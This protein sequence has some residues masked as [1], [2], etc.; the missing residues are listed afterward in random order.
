MFS[1]QTIQSTAHRCYLEEH[2]PKMSSVYIK[3]TALS[4]T[5]NKGRW[6]IVDTVKMKVNQSQ[7]C[8]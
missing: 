8:L 4:A 6:E 2:A 3:W 5:G 7:E 1:T